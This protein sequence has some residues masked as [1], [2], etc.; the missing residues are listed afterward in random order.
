MAERATRLIF[1]GTPDF[2]VPSLQAILDA[3]YRPSLV[4]TQP[5]RPA[6]RGQQPQPPP[7][8]QLA[9]SAGLP[10]EQPDRLDALRDRLEAMRPEVMVVVA[11]AHKIPYWLL[12]LPPMGVL[13]VHASLLPKYRGASPVAAALLAG[14]VET[15][16]SIMRL[17]EGWDTGPV[18]RQRSVP[19]GANDDGGQLT[20]RLARIGAELLIEVLDLRVRGMITAKRQDES[21]ASYA[22]RLSKQD[23]R[24]DWTKD[25]ARLAREVRAYTPWPGSFTSW[26]GKTVKIARAAGVPEDAPSG[27]VPGTVLAGLRVVT[28]SG[29]LALER[30][31]M[32]GR[33]ASDAADFLRGYPA[34]LGTRLGD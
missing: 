33:K 14:D 4:L 24:I 3:G 6:G 19:I 1:A 18:F 28:G 11:F 9:L 34:V 5:D 22:P 20:D 17:A 12:T 7:V 31:Q 26:Q 30:L 10:I 27:T 13:N 16:V 32:E 8:K 15:G 25:A 23:G 29:L 21:K 2:A